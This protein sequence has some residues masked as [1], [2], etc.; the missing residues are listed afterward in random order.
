[1]NSLQTIRFM[2]IFLL[3]GVSC[4]PGTP[5]PPVPVPA[6]TGA[7]A[8][9]LPEP[10]TAEPRPRAL[11]IHGDTRSDDYYWLRERD[12]PEVIAYLERENAYTEAL[13][14]HT[15]PLRDTLFREIKGRIKQD[16]SS[17]PV[18]I[19]DYFYYT[20]YEEGE[21]YPMRARKRG[22]LDAPEE[23]LLDQNELAEGHGFYSVAGFRTSP[24]HRLLGFADDTVGR[25]V[26]TLRFKDLDS[27]EMLPDEIPGTSG[28]FAW[29]NDNR[30][31]FYTVRDPQTLRSFRVFRHAVGT[32][33][34]ADQLVYQESDE[35]FSVG[36]GKTKSDAYLLIGSYQTLS[37]EYRYLDAD[38][39][40]G[41][42]TLFA[43]RREEHEYHVDHH[44]GHFYVRSNREGASNFMLARTP[45]ANTT[46]PAW[47]VVIPHRDDVLLQSFELFR[48]HLVVSERK[49][50]LVQLRVR[51]LSDG[52][53]HYLDFDEAAYLA[54]LTGNAE[55][56]TGVL[57]FG[58]TSMTTPSST[59][60]Y[61]M[62]T[63]ERTLLK[64]EEVLGGGFDPAAY[65]TERLDVT[66][67]DGTRV[68]VSLVYRADTRTDSA[69]LLVYGYGSYGASI[70]ATFSHARLSLL[71]RGWVYAIAHV[72][73]GQ[74]LGRGWYEDGKLL[75]KK[76]TFTDFIDVSE[77]LLR[78]GYGDPGQLF[79]MGG[80]AGGLLMGAVV[81]L[82]PD[83]YRGVIAAVPFVDVVTT[84]LDPTIPL[85]TFE[86]DE[87]GNPN[88]PEYYH[89]I[90]SY[91]PYDNVEP[92]E[93][94]HMLV[95]TGLHDSQVQ[96]WEPAKWVAKLRAVKTGDSVLLLKT[97][98]EAGHG[99]AS[100]RDERYREIAFEYAF[101]L[102]LARPTA[103]EP[104][105]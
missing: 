103:G 7:G 39:P 102:D 87:W 88:D 9:E 72:R 28:N 105:S 42:W 75:N 4:A 59:Y 22:S 30:T 32:D 11:T 65:R 12:N 35:E 38:D 49:G 43:P 33:P 69:P 78:E 48:D 96:Y 47:E 73:G 58:Y 52:S 15:G 27:K 85:T 25:R 2:P 99:G 82:R 23:V 84:M 44:D 57:R 13:T 6:A 51:R 5:P 50:G 14:A 68:P 46:E 89:Y 91:S 41:E 37:T 31:V 19:D 71:E 70:D 101:L 45:L 24:D 60:D 55:F 80:S 77:F 21:D 104:G 93:Y 94:P 34:A 90:L 3:A 56:E 61:D 54:Y 98:M 67:R 81:N 10:P 17:V 53:E 62:G 26:Y 64:R 97:K 92:K 74:E 86:Y 76:N 100:A 79:A 29:A 8:S 83:L 36:V 63:R 95:T 18:R 20:R 16:D 40:A 66:A 1:M